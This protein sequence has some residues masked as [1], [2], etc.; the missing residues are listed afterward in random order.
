MKVY[1]FS[2]FVAVLVL[3]L[4]PY[5]AFAQ[6]AAGCKDHQLFTRMPYFYIQ[7][8]EIKEFDG[9]TFYLSDDKE[10]VVEG[11]K[12]YLSHVIKENEK[13]PSDL[14]ILRNFENAVKNVGGKTEYMRR[15]DGYLSI[16]KGGKET[17]VHVKSW[18]DGEGYDLTII[19]KKGME[20][21]I[22]ANAMLDAL[23]KEGFIALYINFDTNKATIK[24]ES[25]PIVDQLVGLLTENPGLR[26]S[27]EGHTDSTGNAVRNKTLSQQRAQS[28]VNVL[29]AAGI[30]KQRLSAIGWGQEKPVADNRT[31]E[32]R[33]KNRR[34]EIVKK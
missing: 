14:Q 12:T 5:P 27:I 1:S 19:E 8:C 20:Q 10:I 18:N 26:V 30:E 29:V 2:C 24:P 32:G 15:Y 23:N 17:W 3:C 6:D 33:A 25:K 11:K 34:V 28:V 4:A 13:A 21:E 16:R 31:D 22:T 9:H 7:D